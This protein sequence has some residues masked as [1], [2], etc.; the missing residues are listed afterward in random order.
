MA[1]AP[2][3]AWLAALA[4]LVLLP[5]MT[6]AQNICRPSELVTRFGDWSPLSIP[7]RVAAPV[8]PI[9]PRTSD[10]HPAASMRLLI[11]A[12]QLGARPWS[13]AIRDQKGHLVAQLERSDF[14]AG[15]NTR[16]TGRLAGPMV[17]VALRGGDTDTL[18]E[19][20]GA[21]ANGQAKNDE[22]AFS[23]SGAEPSWRP[24]YPTPSISRR[25]AGEAVGIF[26][27]DKIAPAGAGPPGTRTSW[28]CSGVMIGRDLFLTNWH[29]AGPG[30]L[31]DGEVVGNAIIDL[32]WE[33]GP[34]RRQFSVKEVVV[35]D[36]RL[37]FAILRVK[38][39]LGA[40]GAIRESFPVEI[41][42]APITDSE[43]IFMIHHAQCKPKLVS[44]NCRV[45]STT[46]AAWTDPA[47]VAGERTEITH[48]CDTEPG[49]SGAPIFDTQGRLIA[50][51]HLGHQK[52]ASPMCPID[53]AN[54]AVKMS[55]IVTFLRTS[56]DPRTQAL[57]QELGW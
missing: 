6:L 36:E 50:L 3:R 43:P 31:W 53:T 19:I 48:N 12:P 29:C 1:S 49:A 22:Q 51:H 33:D 54:K 45:Q 16:W 7:I 11:A 40:D 26:V 41:S 9:E 18:V 30:Q 24:L 17:T 38:P 21:S 35:R 4:G 55:A 46:R 8:Q 13:L 2:F 42:T 44:D 5:A 47:G 23:I 52:S 10:G 56:G 20:R 32:A 39:A 15:V 27:D 37:D 57:V 28:C 34:I 14:M 25:N